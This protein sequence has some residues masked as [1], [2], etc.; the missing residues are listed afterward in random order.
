VA[1]IDPLRDDGL[2]YA[3]RL[4]D[5]GV[6]VTLHNYDQM[7]HGFFSRPTVF[8]HGAEAIARVGAQLREMIAARL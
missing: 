3:Q 2:H 5:A 6:E 4:R 7:P 1:E 8:D